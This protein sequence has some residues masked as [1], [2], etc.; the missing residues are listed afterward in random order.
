ME[1]STK[2]KFFDDPLSTF[3]SWFLHHE[4]KQMRAVISRKYEK[5]Y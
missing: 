5:T 4:Q 1:N 3:K 2:I